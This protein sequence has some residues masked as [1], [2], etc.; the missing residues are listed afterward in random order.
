[1]T[2]GGAAGRPAAIGA[3]LLSG[4]AI[5]RRHAVAFAILGAA[6]GV[7]PEVGSL[8]AEP[9]FM[10]G[11]GGGKA[12]HLLP[13]RLLSGVAVFAA[14]SLGATALDV[15]VVA[16][17]LGRGHSVGSVL[18]LVLRLLPVNLFCCLTGALAVSA[19]PEILGGIIA[20]ALL[21]WSI[22]LPIFVA[23]R[24]RLRDLPRRGL[25][26][27]RRRPGPVVA[28]FACDLALTSAVAVDPFG[29]EPDYPLASAADL[30]RAV[31]WSGAAFALQI[32]ADAV[33]TAL[34]LALRREEGTAQDAVIASAFE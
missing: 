20:A 22:L 2:G 11:G 34:Y 14:A 3:V 24:V 33:F 8:Q 31:A 28:L 15:A 25:A 10:S 5:L 17:A 19:A 26:L 21:S 29:F 12:E 4:L 18:R 32:T 1:M 30:S 7:L 23:E 27:M 9:F 6:L 16:V 13:L